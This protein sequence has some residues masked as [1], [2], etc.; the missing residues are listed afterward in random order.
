MT[1]NIELQQNWQEYKQL[2]DKMEDDH[3]RYETKNC[4]PI[5]PQ[6]INSRITN[7]TNNSTDNLNNY[8]DPLDQEQ[9]NRIEEN[10][11]ILTK[12]QKSLYK[13]SAPTGYDYDDFHSMRSSHDNYFEEYLRSG[14]E[15]N[16]RSF[17]QKSYYNTTT[18]SEG[19]YIV[20]QPMMRL[21]EERI[22]Q[23]SPMR[24]VSNVQTISANSLDIVLN[25]EDIDAKWVSESQVPN[26]SKNTNFSKLSI[27]AH[28][29]Y[30][31][32]SATQKMLDDAAI[33][34][35]EWIVSEII[36]SF[37]QKENDSFTNGP[38]GTQPDG[39]LKNTSVPSINAGASDSFDSDNL[40]DL[41]YKL[42]SKY[43]IN[44]KMMMNRSLL[45]Y[46]RKLKEPSSGR[47]IWN[48]SQ[49]DTSPS[50][51]LGIPVIENDH[52]PSMGNNNFVIAFGDFYAGYTIVDRRDIRVLRD[53]YSSKPF[54]LFYVTKR[55]GGNVVQPN[56]FCFLKM[57]V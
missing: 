3:T 30:A 5:S 44:A 41:I 51:I 4:L 33:N 11:Q 32:P 19:G 52:M 7:N 39:L 38:S 14:Y 56:A 47:Y 24:Q 10:I 27:I 55:V 17:E 45:S 16:L 18:N 48:P 20:T 13:D 46:I 26:T 28:E 23:L 15:Q 36:Q 9:L 53:P 34:I 8:S 57:A 54:V 42:P 22:A 43:A 49:N 37:A 1:Y 6:A 40:L 25:D 35:E 12:Q 29:I 31:M 2:N 50:T 21:Y